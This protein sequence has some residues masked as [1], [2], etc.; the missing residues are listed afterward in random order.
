MYGPRRKRGL[1][2]MCGSAN[3]S[4]AMLDLGY[5]VHG[6]DLL[7]DQTADVLNVN[8]QSRYKQCILS[9]QFSWVHTGTECTTFSAAAN[10]PYRQRGM[11][12][13]GWPSHLKSRGRRQKCQTGNA[14][15]DMTLM[16][17]KWCDAG[18]TFCSVENPRTS[19]L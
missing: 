9:G 5:E 3:F 15:A 14:L 8:L 10:P 2:I 12:I 1:E 6:H 7:L 18:S 13:A 16:V 19:R 11:H 4:S 17:M